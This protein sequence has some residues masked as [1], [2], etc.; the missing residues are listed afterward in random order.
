MVAMSSPKTAQ[1]KILDLLAELLPKASFVASNVFSWSPHTQTITYK[2]S[3]IQ[4]S[5]G[6]WSLLHEASHA[7]LG[8]SNY[9]SDF[10]LLMLEVAA[11]DQAKSLAQV[12]GQTIDE[13][14]VQDCIDTYRDWLHQRSTCPT[15][16]NAGLQ[17]SSTDYHCHN[18]HTLWH[19][20]ASRFCRPYRRKQTTIEKSPGSIKNQT[21]FQ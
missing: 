8:H 12:Y 7:V 10:E 6:A 2:L 11:W 9:D 19:V 15:C 18:C 16:G 5:E 3:E 1:P 4:T 13:N 20:T 21:T 17:Q 14:H